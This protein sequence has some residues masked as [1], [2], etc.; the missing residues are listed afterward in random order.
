MR[1]PKI[2]AAGLAA[3]LLPVPMAWGDASPS[4]ANG[5][6]TLPSVSTAAQ[7]GQY[8]DAV[9]QMNAQGAWTLTSLRV[10]DG[11][12][13]VYRAPVSQVEVIKTAETPAQILLR[14]SGEFS[15]GC[16]SLGRVVQRR[17]GSH[18]EIL[19][20]DAFTA[21][22]VALCTANMVPYVK[23]IPLDAY[24]LAA[25]TYSYDING[26]TGSFELTADNVLSGDCFGSSAC[27][28]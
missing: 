14:V 21:Y 2:L 24:G 1:L 27:Q 9:L 3:C 26:T 25:G 23:T 22:D 15:S 10:L 20:T 7:V 11:S 13:Q 16:G 6:L 18:F 28:N 17:E 5:V 8:Q 19:L 4:Y 12:P